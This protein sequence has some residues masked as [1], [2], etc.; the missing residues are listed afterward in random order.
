M[1]ARLGLRLLAA[2]QA[3]LLIATLVLPALVFADEP[4]P[5]DSPAPT[6]QPSIPP[7]SD[8]TSEPTAPPSAPDPT[9][10]PTPPPAAP[11]TISSDKADYAPG[12]LVT[13][14]GSGWAPA[15]SV[16]LYVNDEI[17]STWGRDVDVVADNAGS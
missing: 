16:H 6:E 14:T 8:P 10:E 2:L 11:P 4:T 12:E 9:Q 17:G 3:F 7:S 5:T 13:L 15:E 1:H